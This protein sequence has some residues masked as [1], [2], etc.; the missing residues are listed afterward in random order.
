MPRSI[1]ATLALFMLA[2]AAHSSA[3]TE[4]TI[5]RFPKGGARGF[6]PYSSLVA[7]SAGNLYGTTQ[8]GGTGQC[9]N[10]AKAKIGCGTVFR[11]TPPATSGGAWTETVLYSFQGNYDG[12]LPAGGVIL[13]ISGDLY[14]TTQYGGLEG[15]GGTVFEL[16]PPV[17]GD[18]WSETI[19]HSF[20]DIFDGESMPSGNLVFDSS[21][22]LYGTTGA[23]EFGLNCIVGCGSV[24]QL[25][26]PSVEGGQWTETELHGF[27]GYDGEGP[28]GGLLLRKGGVLY[29]TT[30]A[31]G[32]GSGY[33]C[34]QIVSPD[35]CGADFEITPPVVAGGA[36]TESVIY[37]PNGPP[38][39]LSPSGGLVADAA[40]NLYGVSS[41]G[42]TGTCTD[43]FFNSCGTVFQLVPPT[44]SGGAWIENILYNFQGGADGNY[45]AGVMVF[46]GTG[47]LYGTT[48]D[49]GNACKSTSAGC[50]T[51]FKLTPPSTSGGS[52]TKTTVHAFKGGDGEWPA[53]GLLFSNGALYGITTSGGEK[54][55]AP[56]SGGPQTCGVVFKIVP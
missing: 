39:T 24:F 8:Y 29:G 17:S 2:T 27:G 12:A 6:D 50:G 26:P 32:D 41:M 18:S 14:G 38:D 36:W 30:I 42:G 37:S 22:N 21:G 33:L 49:G 55:P 9:I 35:G 19:L 40:G 34:W 47:N 1:F 51:I 25:A 48:F 31:G 20:Y 23:S 45:P 5:Y 7:D 11:L 13:G 28:N 10:Y 52:W 44:T 16:M 54:C 43:E 56:S 3:Q 53:T 15:G 46:D 4:F